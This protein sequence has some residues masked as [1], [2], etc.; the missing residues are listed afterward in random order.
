MDLLGA[1]EMSVKSLCWRT[2]TVGCA[3]IQHYLGIT[4]SGPC[5]FT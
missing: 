5:I 3:P 4:L 1:T 2:E